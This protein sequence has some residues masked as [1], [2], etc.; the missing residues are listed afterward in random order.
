MTWEGETMVSRARPSQPDAA[1]TIDVDSLLPMRRAYLRCREADGPQ[2]RPKGDGA[3]L[4]ARV[5]SEEQ[6]GPGRPPS[7]NSSAYAR[8][9][10]PAPAFR[11]SPA[12]RT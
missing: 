8:K 10:S 5:S 6:A 3:H 1:D 12:G 7:V 11:L 4:Y 2:H 9:R